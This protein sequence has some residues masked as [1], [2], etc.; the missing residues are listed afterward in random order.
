MIASE[1]RPWAEELGAWGDAG[2]LALDLLAEKAAGGVPDPASVSALAGA[3]GVLTS[4]T[5][6]PTGDTMPGFIARTLEVLSQ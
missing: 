3:H 5:P 4:S 6:R 1:V 2:L